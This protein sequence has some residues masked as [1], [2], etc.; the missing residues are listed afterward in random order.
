MK[1]NEQ[2]GE[3]YPMFPFVLLVAALNVGIK[4]TI[5]KMAKNKR[6]I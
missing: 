3:V 2:V 6:F 5:R 4:N 1:A